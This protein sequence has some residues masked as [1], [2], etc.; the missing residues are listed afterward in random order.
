[1]EA[2]SAANGSSY[3]RHAVHLDAPEYGTARSI[4]NDG[5]KPAVNPAD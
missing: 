1:M 5:G 4:F 3:G 2:G